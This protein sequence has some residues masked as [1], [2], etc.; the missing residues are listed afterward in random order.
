MMVFMVSVY[1]RMKQIRF[2][3]HHSNHMV[4]AIQTII[5]T[6]G[7]GAYQRGNCHHGGEFFHD[8]CC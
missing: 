8:A 4:P 6:G 1:I 5:F 7:G 3:I 2:L